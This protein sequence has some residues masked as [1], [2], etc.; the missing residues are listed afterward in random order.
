[1]FDSQRVGRSPLKL[2]PG[3]VPAFTA[4]DM[5]AYLQSAPECAVGPTFSGEPPIIETLEFVGCKELSRRLKLSIG[6][7]DDALV[8]YVVLLG[9]FNATRI[10][11]PPGAPPGPHYPLRILEIYDARTGRLLVMSG[12]PTYDKTRLPADER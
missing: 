12:Y 6:L 8:C 2:T 11:L 5:R 9:P 7:P 1:M 4:D 3:K 10:S